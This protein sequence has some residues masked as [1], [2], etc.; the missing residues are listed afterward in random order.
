MIY[1]AGNQAR[2]DGAEGLLSIDVEWHTREGDNQGWWQC[3]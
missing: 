2:I 3:K 1:D